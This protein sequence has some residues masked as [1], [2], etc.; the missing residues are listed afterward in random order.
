MAGKVLSSR[1]F[2]PTAAASLQVLADALKRVEL[3]EKTRR[4]INGI[5]KGALIYGRGFPDYSNTNS[6]V[7]SLLIPRS[8][9]DAQLT[10]MIAEEHKRLGRPI[11]VNMLLVLKYIERQST[12]RCEA[13]L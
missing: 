2:V 5:F 10:K 6:A 13:A 1:R 7:M 12:R 8:K 11:P 4:G 9:P 3:A